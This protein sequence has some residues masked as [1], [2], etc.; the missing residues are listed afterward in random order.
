MVDGS[1]AN[2]ANVRR[3]AAPA[4]GRPTTSM[5]EILDRAKNQRVRLR[6]R[7]DAAN[8]TR[9]SPGVATQE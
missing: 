9:A 7:I 8:T 6:A 3:V 2:S 4:V 5:E 1:G